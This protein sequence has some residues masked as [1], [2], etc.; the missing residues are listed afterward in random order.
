MGRKR[1]PQR[2]KVD[3]AFV[4]E[5]LGRRHMTQNEMAALMGITGDYLSRIL[6]GTRCT[7]PKVRRLL[8]E[9]LGCSEFEALFIVVNG[10]E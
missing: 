9:A 3:G 4:R 2:V 10:D 1:S 7:S 5:W 6:N 8:Q